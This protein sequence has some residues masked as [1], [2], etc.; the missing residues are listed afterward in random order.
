MC[1]RKLSRVFALKSNIMNALRVVRSYIPN[2][3][4]VR[5]E[6]ANQCPAKQGRRLVSRHGRCGGVF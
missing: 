2:V 3:G 4:E 1:V 5:G 6:V